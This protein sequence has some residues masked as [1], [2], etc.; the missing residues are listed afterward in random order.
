MENYIPAISALLGV[1]LGAS[2][3]MYVARLQFRANVISK[4][5]QE[6]SQQLR[7]N[8]AEYESFATRFHIM[9]F[10]PVE[11]EERKE[12]RDLLQRLVFYANR[13]ALMLDLNDSLHNR[14]HSLII[15]VNDELDKTKIDAN[16]NQIPQ[17]LNTINDVAR[18]L[19]ASELEKAMSG[20]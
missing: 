8:I 7:D 6:W 19:F 1:L 13:V 20:K 4:F 10:N 18:S 11:A 17:L 14:L 3:S 16:P 15:Q 2:V 12:Q 9:L 5:R